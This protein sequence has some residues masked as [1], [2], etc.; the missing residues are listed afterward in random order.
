MQIN[1]GSSFYA[2]SFESSHSSVGEIL[3]N[4]LWDHVRNIKLNPLTL[5][6]LMLEWW[7]PIV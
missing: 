6:S 7:E 2:S 4:Q 1:R 5:P 3:E